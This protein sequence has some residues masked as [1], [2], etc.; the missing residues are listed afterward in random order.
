M[1]S[2]YQLE[3]IAA[4]HRTGGFRGAARELRISQPTLSKAIMRLEASLGYKLFDRSP[5]GARATPAAEYLARGAEPLL[6][7][8]ARLVA[9]AGRRQAG[10]D[11]RLRMGIGPMLKHLLLPDIVR[12]V[13]ERFPNI[14]YQ[15][16][17]TGAEELIEL[18]MQRRIDAVFVYHE[19]ALGHDDLIRAKIFSDDIAVIARSGHPLQNR[20]GVAQQDLHAFPFALSGIRAHVMDWLEMPVDAGPDYGVVLE[21]DSFDVLIDHIRQSDHLSLAPRSFFSD[22]L[23][24]GTIVTIPTAK[25]P[26]TYECWLLSPA[27]FART[28]V[29]SALA[30]IARGMYRAAHA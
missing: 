17:Q 18:A 24:A 27:E 1:I 6:Q 21:S 13:R 3:M 28:P 14:H 30:E 22:L 10:E 7:G 25:P 5:T 26:L 20:D 19:V 2:L 12:R 4:I 23:D 29:F 9:E 16:T 8:A 11:G 15:I